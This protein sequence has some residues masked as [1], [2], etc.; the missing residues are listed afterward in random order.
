MAWGPW[1]WASFLLDSDRGSVEFRA[2]N[3][4]IFSEFDLD[5]EWRWDSFVQPDR[6]RVR[7]PGDLIMPVR[8]SWANLFRFGFKGVT[9]P[10]PVPGFEIVFPH[11]ALA[12][13]LAALPAV[14]V[15]R[16]RRGRLGNVCPACGYDLR[17][18]PDGGTCPECG[19]PRGLPKP[20]AIEA[21]QAAVE[22]A[23]R[24]L[25]EA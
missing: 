22:D 17:G 10:S 18:T 12:V 3:E 24:D 25:D 19:R 4:S 1:V 6:T 8:S 23:L 2:P 16:W 7:R 5:P 15:L 21:E 14:W 13:P 9:S 11:W 20:E